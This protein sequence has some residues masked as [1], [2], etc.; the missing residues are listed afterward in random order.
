MKK[1]SVFITAA[2]CLAGAVLWQI[3]LPEKNYY[4]ICVI[5]IIISM[6]P[7][8]FSFESSAPSAKELALTASLV[9]IAVVS[10]AVFY[11]VPQV[12]PIGAVVIVSGVCLGEKRGYIIGMLSAF[13]SN[14]IFGQGVWTPFQMAALGAVGLLS[15][16][17]F[18]YVKVNRI[19]LSVVGFILCSLVYGAIVDLSSVLIMSYNINLQSVIAVYS[20]GV[21]FNIVFGAATAVFLCVFG[22]AFIK[23]LNRVIAKYGIICIK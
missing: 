19:T 15:G 22:E 13:I 17:I 23:K 6:I 3:F 5:L 21:V 7:F 9:V 18:K 10:R 11:L 16:L 8:V 20:A 12:K 14:F 4:L 1:L 2:L